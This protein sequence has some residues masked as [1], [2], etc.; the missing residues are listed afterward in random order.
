MSFQVGEIVSTPYGKGIV[1]KGEN[2]YKSMV[3][4][5][6]LSWTL[7]DGQAPT[8]YLNAADVKPFYHIN[9]PIHT[10]FGHG[11]I[12]DIRR[13]SKGEGEKDGDE[14]G[15][16]TYLVQLFN[17][18]L[19][20]GKSP[21]LYLNSQALHELSLELAERYRL[22]LN[23]PIGLEVI[24]PYGK[25]HVKEVRENNQI[26]IIPSEWKLATGKPPIFYMN[27]ASITKPKPTE[28]KVNY[29]EPKIKRVVELKDRGNSLVSANDYEGAKMSYSQALAILNYID[30][31]LEIIDKAMLFEQ[32]V[33]L[34]NN[35]SLCNFKLKKNSESEMFAKSNITLIESIERNMSTGELWKCLQSR[36]L[37]EETVIK[38][39]KKRAYYYL[40]K[41]NAE[42]HEYK[43]AI[44]NFK[45]GLELI[46][47]DSNYIKEANELK[48]LITKTQK[49]MEK[50]DQKAK[51]RWS[52]AFK[53][54]GEETEKAENLAAAAMEAVN[55][56][57]STN[58]NSSTSQSSNGLNVFSKFGVSADNTSSAASSSNKNNTTV[59]KKSAGFSWLNVLFPVLGVVTI[60]VAGYFAFG[61]T[62]RLKK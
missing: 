44:R 16:I 6:P 42:T 9:Q 51:H 13:R 4:V 41:A 7:A 2:G 40:A 14:N 24:T 33:P 31:D 62:A 52:Q 29:L 34:Q 3:T 25:G 11:Y 46:A 5:T 1:K 18:K 59:A 21:V 30:D 8:F 45:R 60:G 56:V 48:L 28:K 57:N 37:T 20:T 35:M 54:Q 15:V 32:L 12:T 17:W 43:E 53:K 10:T 27:A 39:W 22:V 19:A 36:G 49:I 58:Q 23:F 47:N 55:A 38:K 61:F 26:V 50:E